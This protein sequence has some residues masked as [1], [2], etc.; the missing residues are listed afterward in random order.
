M[1]ITEKWLGEIAGW[2]A[3]KA[4]RS[5]VAGGQVQVTKVEAGL[6][7]GLSGTGRVQFKAGLRIRSRSDVDNLCTCS[8]ARR[9]GAMCEHSIA[10]ALAS[11]R[12]KDAPAARSS[13]PVNRVKITQS[14]SLKRELAIEAVRGRFSIYLPDQVRTGG[15]KSA[16]GVFM[17]YESGSD[18]ESLALSRWLA[19][20]GVPAQSTPL[21]L[22]GRDWTNFLSSLGDH[23]RV[24]VGKPSSPTPIR[25]ADTPLNLP[26]SVEATSTDEVTFERLDQDWVAITPPEANASWWF[27]SP[28]KTLFALPTPGSGEA[29]LLVAELA[30]QRRARRSLR[31]WVQHR[32]AIADSLQIEPRGTLMSRFH[33]APVP[34]RFGIEIDGSLQAALVKVRVTH[35]DLHWSLAGKP[36]VNINNESSFPIQDKVATSVFYVRNEKAERRLMDVLEDLGFQLDSTGDWRLSGQNKVLG[37]FGGGIPRLTA[38]GQVEYSQRWRAATRGLERITPLVRSAGEGSDQHGRDGGGSGMD[39]L[40]ME[41]RYEATDGFRLPRNEILRL[42]RAGQSSVPGR[43]GKRYVIDSE[44][45]EAFE[46]SLKDVPLEM[47]AEG[48]RVHAW[49]AHAL[50]GMSEDA[51]SVSSGTADPLP[52]AILRERVGDLAEILRDYQLTGVRWME[53]RARAGQGGILADDMGLGKTLQ[54]IALLRAHRASVGAK[55]GEQRPALV[56]C[57]RSLLGNWKAEFERFAPELRVEISHGTG[58]KAVHTELVNIDVILTTYALVSRDLAFL[59]S[60]RFGVILLDEASYIRN[61]DTAAAKALRK[62]PAS[63]RF[64]LTGT[65]IENTVRDLWSILNF[66]LP[67]YLGDRDHFKERFEQPLATGPGTQ[68]GKMASARLQRLIQPFF[69]RRT[70]AEVLKELPE[71]IEQ[72]LWCDPSAA[73]AQLYNRLLDEGR[74]EIR[75]AQKRSGA[76]GAKMTMFTV[77]L[78]LRQVC[79]DLRLTG[80]PNEVTGELD[81]E[82]LSAKWPMFQDRL[83]QVLASDGKVLIFSQFVTFLRLMR[84]NLDSQNINY[85]YLDGSTSDR[86][87]QVDAFQN[88]PERRVFLI[89]LKAGGYGLNLTAADHVF[90]MDPWWNPAVESQAI[91]RAHRMGQTNVVNAYRFATRGTVE[92]RI[93]KLQ[94]KKRGLVEAALTEDGAWSEGATAEELAEILGV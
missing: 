21:S 26:V 67:G 1:E 41:F 79:C 45:I 72:V 75:A 87:A 7:Q 71:K 52:E 3:M 6:V 9:T 12:P 51:A 5:L 84:N 20:A 83:D 86:Q 91:D 47:T 14:P 80:L 59:Q 64:A 28:T 48:A 94:E 85:S 39:W 46:D 25:V 70:K 90:L 77:L 15:L 32:A 82:D 93:L 68:A 44:A 27:C 76:G 33:V 50:P 10:I 36:P 4:A 16:A 2:A 29:A 23:P 49:H 57:P 56:V 61:P 73:Q 78:R 40:S 54:S 38:L 88:Q 31:W 55:E 81:A 92:E 69:L 8:T 62:I 17:K 89:S 13:E 30:K 18:S 74:D 66:T 60:A 37:F 11:L 58:R 19:E 22:Q 24:F 42:V 53:A 34:C 43:Q 65:P 35:N 63:V